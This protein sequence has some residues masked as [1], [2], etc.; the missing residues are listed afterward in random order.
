MEYNN[1]TYIASCVFTKENPE[2]SFRIQKYLQQK[3]G[4]EIIRCCVEKYKVKE[5]EESM[6]ALI[7]DDWKKI[8]HY[9]PFGTDS[10]MVSVCHNCSAIFQET[11]PEIKVV[12]LWEFILSDQDFQYPD[13]RSEKMTVQDCWRSYDNREEQDAVRALLNNMNIEIA[14]LADHHEKTQFCGISLFQPAPVRNLKLAPTR[15]VENAKGLFLSHAD[16]ELPA[17]MQNH[18]QQI[19]TDKVV[20]YCHYCVKGLKVGGKQGGHLAELLFP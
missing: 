19:T 3:H 10:I 1:F 16:E 6:P 14:E 13:Y 8:P 17:L 7:Q 11:L 18:C 9:K 2:L 12:S 5:F 20:A 15:F 4:M